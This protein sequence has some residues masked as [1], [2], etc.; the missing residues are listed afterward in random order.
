[1]GF[2]IFQKGSAPMSKVPSVTIQK[3]GLI[4]LNRAAHQMI[5]EPE[6]VVLMWDSDRRII[7]LK[8]AEVA[9]PNGYPARPQAKSGKGPVLI[10][11]T[12]FTQYIGLDTSE[13]QRWV[14][15]EEDDVLCIDVSEPGAKVTSN[16]A[17]RAG[18]GAEEK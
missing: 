1:M 9:D 15:T 12:L 11:G 4:S 7:G 17:R 3:R 18:G 6:A 5:G 10:A 16:R 2:E 14:P 8:P 13:A